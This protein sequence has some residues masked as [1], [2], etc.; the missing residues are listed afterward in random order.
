[1]IRSIA[2][3][4]STKETRPLLAYARTAGKKPHL[5][6]ADGSGETSCKRCMAA[7]AAGLRTMLGARRWV[8][9]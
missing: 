1:M 3:F 2:S 8:R 5:N 6:E 7:F 9:T 4:R